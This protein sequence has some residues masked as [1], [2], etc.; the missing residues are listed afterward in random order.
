MVVLFLMFFLRIWGL[1]KNYLFIWLHQVLIA[2]CG[3]FLVAGGLFQ[4]RSVGSSSPTRDRTWAP[5][6]GSVESGVLTTGP[7]GKFLFL[8]F[9]EP[10]Y[11]FPQWLHQF[12]FLPTVQE[13]FLFSR[14][15]LTLIISSLFD[16]SH[17]NRCEVISH[18]GFDLHSL[19]HHLMIS[20]V[21]QLFMQFFA[22]CLPSLQK[23][24]FRSSVRFLIGRIFFL[25]LLSCMSSTY[26]LNINPLSDT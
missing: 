26:V 4:L 13:G 23:C 3:I 9:E 16:D 19:N 11:H 12:T 14:S 22:I 1:K 5:C 24:L 25:L 21:E 15:S 2:A 6:I 18:C 17:S 10:S 7:P 20:D 8:F